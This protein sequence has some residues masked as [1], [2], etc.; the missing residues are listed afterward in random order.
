ML[1]VLFGQMY[2]AP[3]RLFPREADPYSAAIKFTRSQAPLPL[4]EHR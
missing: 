4:I 2:F 3:A 1:F